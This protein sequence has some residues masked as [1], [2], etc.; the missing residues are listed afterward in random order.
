MIHWDRSA[1]GK[2]ASEASS[3]H[4]FP[5]SIFFFFFFLGGGLVSDNFLKFSEADM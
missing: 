4:N 5:K 1:D 3:H 2:G